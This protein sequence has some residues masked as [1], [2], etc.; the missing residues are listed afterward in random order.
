MTEGDDLY[1]LPLDR[2][3]SERGDLAKALRRSGEK[4]EAARV[5]GLRKPSVAAWVV[6][7]L[8]R[9]QRSAV[10]ALFDAGDEAQRVQ[11]ELL[12]GHGDAR[13][14]RE[15]ARREREAVAQLAEVA[16]GLLTSEGQEPTQATLERVSE[17]LRAAAL[18]AE[19]RAQVQ[20]GRLVRELR[21]VGF[22]AGGLAGVAPSARGAKP[23]AKRAAPDRKAEARE[24]AERAERDRAER[25]KAARQAEA[26]ARREA[27]QTARHLHAAEERRERAADAL[28]EAEDALAAARE[29]AGEAAREHQRVQES[30]GDV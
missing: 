1:G 6:N 25:R 7:Q 24:E 16:R 9:T 23:A 19:A 11:S 5:A 21:Q 28:R 22:G 18:D 2:F 14:L 27:E 29:R 4:E 13:A 17:T 20:D 30:L 26:A 12:A 3:V 15:A 8:V 10:A